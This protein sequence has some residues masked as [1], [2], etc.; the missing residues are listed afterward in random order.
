MS[1]GIWADTDSFV[2]DPV[3][4]AAVLRML[5]LPRI[6]LYLAALSREGGVNLHQLNR[7]SA[8]TLVAMTDEA[9]RQTRQV[10]APFFSRAGL[11]CWHDTMERAI[12]SAL[13]RLASASEPDLVSDFTIP[14]FLEVVPRVLGLPVGMSGD[15]FRAIETVQ[16]ITEPYLSVA[17][18]RRL[19]A[20]VGR[21]IDTCPGQDAP[22]MQGAPETLLELLYRQRDALPR[23]LDS[24]YVVL[25]LLVG[26]NSATQSLA[27]AV[28]G[29]LTGPSA[30]WEAVGAAGWAARE[31]DRTLSLYQT[32]RT[33]VRT[34]SRDTEVAGCPYHRGETA[35]V[36]IVNVNTHLRREAAAGRTHMSFGSGV[37]KCPGTY[38]TEMLFSNALPALARRFPRLVLHKE[39]CRFV[40]TPMMQAPSAL[41]CETAV[42]SRRISNRMCDIRDMQ[43]ARD[44]VSETGDFVPPRMEEHL[45][46]L[47]QHSGR[48]LTTAITVARNAMF[49]MT[50]ERHLVL[51]R[52]IAD[53]LGGSRL[54]EWSNVIHAAI[55]ESLDDLAQ[56]DRPDLVTG[57]A[58]RMRRDVA[59]HIL[60]VVPSD[61]DRFEALAPELQDILE[62]WLPM[63]EL[64]RVQAVFE[65]A[66]SV[67][68]V[69]E[70]R[71]AP[72]PLL[73][74]LLADQPEGFTRED[75]KAVVLVLYG[76]SFNLSHTL[77]NCLHWIL[78][79][80]AEQR[81]GAASPDWIDARLEQ[82]IALCA[83]PKFIYRMAQHDRELGDMTL[84]QGD[85]ARLSLQAINREGVGHFS[86]GH[87]LHSCVGAGFSRLV[88][89]SAIPALFARFPNI[90][91][92]P[93]G[94]AYF[95]M[96]QTVALSALPSR[97]G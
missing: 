69:A 52:H 28:Y 64:A 79:R 74:G 68:T 77:A 9:H 20:A 48:D 46:R 16:R 59:A 37:H 4:A 33:L 61:P 44:V 84:R 88:I 42:R 66:L 87:G 41:P 86:F 85:T 35:V 18:L 2:S 65:E 78:T 75:L 70:V 7:L 39:A 36:D 40:H 19:D 25:G 55:E 17:T 50:G 8:N 31:L 97:L 12:E 27:F 56:M 21:L 67:L 54:A 63:R 38:L 51:R 71:G 6:D 62:P 10:I 5:D 90:S 24:R 3:K 45:T 32:T 96:S 53:R 43:L 13:D 94:H 89:R 15:H 23:D 81:T 11:A 34:A 60:G 92:V 29:L 22:R 82:L 30:E 83:S 91:L 72:V 26:A 57:L 47:A 49:F 73:N 14:L 80:P 95:S 93:Q 58:D 1:R 76:A